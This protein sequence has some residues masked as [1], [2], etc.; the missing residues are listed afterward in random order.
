MPNGSRVPWTTSV[1]T[2][3]A[4]SSGRRLG[5]ESID[6]RLQREGEAEHAGRARRRGGAAGDAGSRRPAADDERQPEELARDEVL[7]DRRPRR[8]ELLGRRG[9]AAARDA[10]WLLYEGDG[11]PFR[12]CCA[13]RGCE[14]A[15]GDPAAGAVTE[16]ER[17]PRAGVGVDVP[18]A[19]PCRVSTSIVGSV[20]AIDEA[21][22]RPP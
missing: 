17:R 14:I 10:A 4:S 15:C 20:L 8:V 12:Q 18:R 7:D 22:R 19:G 3:T 13:G 11:E 9:R 21:V 2:V 5:A 16:D 1:G 6:R